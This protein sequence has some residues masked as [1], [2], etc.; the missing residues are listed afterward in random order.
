MERLS[1]LIDDAE[2]RSVQLLVRFLADLINC[3]VVMGASLLRLFDTFIATA[4]EPGVKP[5][6]IFAGGGFF[7]VIF[8]Q[9]S[10]L[11]VFP[12]PHSEFRHFIT[13]KFLLYHK[14]IS[15]KFLSFINYYLLEH[16]RLP[17]LHSN[18]VSALDW[19]AFQR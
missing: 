7:N 4:A 3:N 8:K 13:G 15:H 11:E 6:C 18:A 17:A 12:R 16:A 2:W 9:I 1:T 14:L 19:T 10:E 5:V